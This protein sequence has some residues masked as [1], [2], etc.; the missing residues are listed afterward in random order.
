MDENTKK[1]IKEKFDALPEI[2]QGIILS[3]N[4]QDN[5]IEIGKRHQLNVE[6][7]GILEQETTLAMM[8]LTP[9][10]NFEAELTHELNVDKEKGSLITKEVE[11]K[12]FLKIRE[13]L[14]LMNTPAGEEPNLEGTPSIPG[15]PVQNGFIKPIQKNLEEEKAADNQVLNSAGIEIIPE[16]LEITTKD[17]TPAPIQNNEEITED[18]RMQKSSILAQKLSTPVKIPSIKTEH[19]LP[20]MAPSSSQNK[21]TV[22]PYREI[23]E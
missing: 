17:N 7:L 23:P 20:N 3:S 6:Q 1:I 13:L 16:K 21:P 9:I 14:K 4:Y 22:D 8:G 15:T 12:V 11:E 10:K 19:S 5:L 2:I 18:Y